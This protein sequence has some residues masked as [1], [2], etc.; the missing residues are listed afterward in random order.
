MKD[1]NFIEN[2]NFKPHELKETLGKVAILEG[3]F[4]IDENG[5][6]PEISEL[7]DITLTLLDIYRNHEQLKELPLKQIDTILM[8]S[9]FTYQDKI[10]GVAEVILA[11]YYSTGWKP[12][13]VINTMDY[14]LCGLFVICNK[15]D[16][17]VF[18]IKESL[19]DD[20]D[21][22]DYQLQKV[23]FSDLELDDKIELMK[24]NWFD[25]LHIKYIDKN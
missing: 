6:L 13:K 7:V 18:C 14:G 2:K 9:T 8:E 10:Y 21:L 24:Y 15:L 1:R 12:K 16:I 25:E 17:D 20:S 22:G 23:Y 11:L 19:H 3:S 5:Y 4:H